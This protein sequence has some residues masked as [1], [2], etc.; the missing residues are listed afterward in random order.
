[1]FFVLA[2]TGTTANQI[3]QDGVNAQQQ[4]AAA[5][6][7]LWTDVL[8]GGLYVAITRLGVLFAVGTL[9]IFLVQWT[10]GVLN[11]ENVNNLAEL[12]WPLLSCSSF[13]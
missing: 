7:N 5:M 13:K 1:M 6:D 2:N 3:L 12:I 9:L 10:K 8:G 11:D 4:I